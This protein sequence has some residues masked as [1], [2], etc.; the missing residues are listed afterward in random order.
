[1][2]RC[3]S[4]VILTILCIFVG[5]TLVGC[6]MAPAPDNRNSDP[7]G[8]GDNPGGDDNTGGDDPPAATSNPILF[9]TQTPHG[10]DFTTVVSTFGNHRSNANAAP[11]GGDLYIRYA[12]GTLRNLTG[13]AGYGATAETE[14]A[15]RD[16]HVHWEGQKALF[17]MVVG[18]VTQNDYD[19]VYW[20]LYEVTGITQGQA[21]SIRKLTQPE[22]YNNVSPAYA[23]DDSIIFTTDRPRNGD[24][25][26]Y[27][28]L[29]E[30]ESSPTVSGLWKMNP[31]GT[32]LQILDHSPSGDFEPFVDSFGRIIFTRWDHLQRDQQAGAD[33]ASIIRG[34]DPSWD[35]VTYPSESSDVANPLGP[36]DEVFPEPQAIYG[37]NGPDPTW[38]DL[39]PTETT[40]RFN[41]FLPWMMNQDG[42]GHE[43]LNHVGRHEM[44]GYI[45]NARTYLPEGYGFTTNRID[46]VMHIE[47]DPARPGYYYMTNTA[48]FGT[49]SAGQIVAINGAPDDNPDDMRIDYITHESTADP[50]QD[51]SPRPAEH[52][53]L[54][55]DPLPATDGTLWAVHSNSALA[56][57]ATANNGPYPAPYQESSRYDF[58]IKQLVPGGPDGAM[59]PGD[60]LNPGGIIENITYFNNYSYRRIEY[61]GPMWELQPVEVTARTR[62]GLPQDDLPQIERDVLTAELGEQGIADLRAYL[63]ANE[64]ALVVSRDVTIRADEQQDIHLSIDSSGHTQ[65]E[66]NV[67]TRAIQYL[68]FFEGQQVRGYYRDGRRVLARPMDETLNPAEANAPAGAVRLGDDGSMAAFVPAKRAMTWQTT[69]A[70]GTP[71]VRERYWLTFQPGE[72]RS[73]VNCHGLNNND[74]FN[75]PGPTNTP[76]ALTDLIQWWK[77]KG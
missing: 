77:V 46:N 23:S 51:N 1:M 62:P 54:F 68:Q 28:Q 53:G 59:I 65:S 49:H 27:P 52:A 13:E 37:V 11:R 3:Q 15:V 20:Q 29:D 64:L 18:G 47:E 63:V 12:D 72:M 25:R 5:T 48:E 32:N 36:G 58:A 14:I 70:D 55:R 30:Y 61:N 74:V 40:L 41:L 71:A 34:N 2:T 35:T 24:R 39:L 22:T 7:V 31:D 60:R 4:S 38:D 76:Q 45:A 42:T 66:P 19:P 16:P 6:P 17:A 26:L 21:V 33:I 8:G 10:R 57:A 67:S 56:D 9:V 44:R 50:V 73:C 75:N 43:T 69:E